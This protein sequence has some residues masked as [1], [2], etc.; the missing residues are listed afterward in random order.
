MSWAG[1]ELRGCELGRNKMLS[2]HHPEYPSYDIKLDNHT[3]CSII[4]KYN[5]HIIS[6]QLSCHVSD[7]ISYRAM[8]LF[9]VKK[10]STAFAAQPG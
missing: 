9:L 8:Y 5:E 7:L 3:P 4:M 2:K 10:Q 1:C 6:N